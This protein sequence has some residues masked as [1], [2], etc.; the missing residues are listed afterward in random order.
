MWE[1]NQKKAMLTYNTIIDMEVEGMNSESGKID[2]FYNGALNEINSL[3]TTIK[4]LK[5]PDI[6]NQQGLPSYYSNIA[7]KIETSKGI[8]ERNI[9]EIQKIANDLSEEWSRNLGYIG[10][11][12][13]RKGRKA[14]R[15]TRKRGSKV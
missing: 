5:V 10:G 4:S 15:K 2:S 9:N 1:K 11:G 12:L 6:D 8:I 14:G 3:Q 13:R 7:N